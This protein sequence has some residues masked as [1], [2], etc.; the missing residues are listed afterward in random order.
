MRKPGA[1]IHG[2]AGIAAFAIIL[3]FMLGSLAAEIARDAAT[4]AA[5]KVAICW[6]LL[7]LVPALIATGG[8]GYQLVR[9]NPMGIAAT[10]F[11]RMRIVGLNGML[12]LVP[13]ALLL[14][15]K[16]GRGEFD[17]LF[18]T[19]QAVEYLAGAVNLSLMG[20]NI[21]DGFRL[22]GRFRRRPM[23]SASR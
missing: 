18:V 11:R 19:V 20:L 23:A 21:R 4:I 14:A 10:K 17:G 15:W 8:S 12:V 7:A 6:G 3:S 13:S 5:T 1:I 9:G 2:A 22:S 16:A